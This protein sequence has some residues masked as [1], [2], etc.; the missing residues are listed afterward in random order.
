MWKNLNN[1]NNN[2]NN[3][4]RLCREVYLLVIGQKLKFD[5]TTKCYMNKTEF[6]LENKTHK[7]IWDFELKTD[8]LILA[9][10]PDLATDPPPKKREPAI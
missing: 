2:N 6:F 1:N 5:P 8:H 9:G 4:N 3:N 10:R 7:I